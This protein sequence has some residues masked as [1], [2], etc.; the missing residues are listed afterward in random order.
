MRNQ[1]STEKRRFY[2]PVAHHIAWVWGLTYKDC[3]VVSQ[4]RDSEECRNCPL[5][6][7]ADFHRDRGKLKREDR[8]HENDRKPSG[9]RRRQD[10]SE[11]KNSKASGS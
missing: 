11:S 3:P 7:T 8:E 10:S 4:E 5:R 6:G 9:R 2:C 1:R